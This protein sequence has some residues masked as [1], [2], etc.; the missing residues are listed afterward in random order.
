MRI[1]DW[2]SDVC[3]SDLPPRLQRE[4]SVRQGSALC[5]VP[6]DRRHY[7]L[8]P[9]AGQRD[10]A[11]LCA[12]GDHR[13]VMLASL[14]VS[15]VPAA[16]APDQTRAP[17]T[18]RDLTEVADIMGPSLSP[19]G[20]RVVF[21]VSRPSISANDTRLDWFV[22]EVGGGTPVHAG[23]A[24]AVR[25]DGAGSVAEQTPV[26]DPDSRGFRF[27]ALVEGAVAI[28]H[29]R[30]DTGPIGKECVSPGRSRWSP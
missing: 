18:A 26:W 11:Q 28:W 13:M 19:D 20:E 9:R 29:W 2:S 17:I 22:A 30:A 6:L 8:R 1:S 3:S 25:H 12:P 16:G 4:Q 24:G 23:S 14:L 5:A 10:R 27:L 21:R 7:R 15:A